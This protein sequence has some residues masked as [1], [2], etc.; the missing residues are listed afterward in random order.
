[1]VFEFLTDTQ[2]FILI[3]LVVS[4]FLMGSVVAFIILQKLY[5][6]FRVTVFERIPNTT[7]YGV[8]KRDKARLI[9]FGDSGEEIYLLKRGK[10]Y[11]KGY[12]KLIGKKHIAWAVGSDDGYWYNI[13]FGDLNKQLLEVGVIPV[14]RDMRF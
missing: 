8:S 4:F 13:T 7:N 2:L 14:D 1:M 5:W 6:P 11:R 9:S 3:I 12:G 10:K